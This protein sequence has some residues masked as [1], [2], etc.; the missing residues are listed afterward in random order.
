MNIISD[1]YCSNEDFNIQMSLQWIQNGI[2]IEMIMSGFKLKACK[3]CKGFPYLQKAGV[4]LLK[5]YS[6]FFLIFKTVFVSYEERAMFKK[7]K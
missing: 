3:E 2:S 1:I 5:Y 6:A 7:W 4:W